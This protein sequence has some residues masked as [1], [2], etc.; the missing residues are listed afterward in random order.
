VVDG[1]IADDRIRKRYLNRF[2]GFA[3]GAQ[4]PVSYVN[5]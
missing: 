4:N 2:V 1:V 3:R 5:L